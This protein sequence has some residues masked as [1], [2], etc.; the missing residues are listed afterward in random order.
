MNKIEELKQWVRD[1]IYR[2]GHFDDVV[3]MIQELRN[4]RVGEL[5]FELYTSSHKYHI[6]AID[7]IQNTGYLGCTA[8]CRKEKPGEN[9]F[10]GSDLADGPFTRETW[11]K[12]KN[13][14]ISHELQKIYRSEAMSYVHQDVCYEKEG[15]V[16]E[17]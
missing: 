11:Q 5:T 3:Y 9:W 6:H 4:P 12:I 14:I 10:R 2:F 17:C 8:S 15:E 13:D 16:K 7:R 1:D